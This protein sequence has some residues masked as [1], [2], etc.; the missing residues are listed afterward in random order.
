[1]VLPETRGRDLHLDT[2]PAEEP[3]AVAA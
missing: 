3:A 1:L 2:A